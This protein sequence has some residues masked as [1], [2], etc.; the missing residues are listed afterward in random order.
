MWPL[1]IRCS[2]AGRSCHADRELY[3]GNRLFGLPGVL[4]Q[5]FLTPATW[6]TIIDD[7][8]RPRSVACPM[9]VELAAP[10]AGEAQHAGKIA[11]I[12]MLLL[13]SADSAPHILE[14]FRR[15]LRELGY[16]EGQNIVIE[17]RYDDP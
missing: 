5:T 13:G 14:A 10:L 16:V 2:N 7:E 11:R 1:L 17:S 15:Q 3:D 9:T 8:R 6:Y 4:S 12:G